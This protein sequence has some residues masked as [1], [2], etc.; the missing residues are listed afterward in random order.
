MAK[1]KKPGPALGTTYNDADTIRLSLVKATIKLLRGGTLVSDLTSIAITNCA[2]VDK[3]YVRRFFGDR[4]RLYLETI[5]HIATSRPSLIGAALFNSGQSGSV[6]PDVVLAFTLFTH[7][8][9]NPEF[10]PQ[11]L[12]LA[13]AVLNSYQHQIEKEF[14]LS[15]ELATRQ[16]V[17]GLMALIGFLTTGHL[18]PVDQRDIAKWLESRRDVLR[19]LAQQHR[20]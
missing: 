12:G 6:D 3:M 15:G 13:E 19:I 10:E 18:L 20:Q 4:D 11:L 16:A 2:K 8:A 5:L 17:L 7:L 14:G 9:R 1:K